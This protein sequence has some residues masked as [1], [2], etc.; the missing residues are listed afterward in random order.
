MRKTGKE[1]KKKEGKER[2]R[3]E[4]DPEI[5]TEMKEVEILK[6]QIIPEGRKEGQ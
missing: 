2:M 1:R 4:T 5:S 6:D 3:E